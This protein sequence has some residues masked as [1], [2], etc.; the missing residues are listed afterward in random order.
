MHMPCGGVARAASV[1]DQHRA[2]RPA[3]R[4]RCTEPGGTATDDDDVV[5]LL[6]L[7]SCL[8]FAHARESADPTAS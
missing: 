7:L 6:T 5:D 2:A 3:Q 8:R 4:Q 1:E